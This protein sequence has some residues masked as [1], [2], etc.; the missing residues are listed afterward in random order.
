MIR[1]ILATL[2]LAPVLFA[3]PKPNIVLILADDMGPGEPSHMGGI[4]P[5]PALD[6]M[7]SEGMRF[8]DAHTTSSVCTPTRYGILT[9]RYNWRSRLKRSVLFNPT[10]RALMDPDPSAPA[11]I[12][13]T[14]GLSHRNGRQMAPRRR[15]AAP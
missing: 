15:L 8:T 14:A 2:L 13:A 11:G 4:V 12:P 7:A 1:T 3:A 6:R 10:D 5:T 9:G